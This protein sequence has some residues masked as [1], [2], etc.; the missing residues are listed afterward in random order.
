MAGLDAKTSGE[1]FRKDHAIILSGNRQLASIMAGRLTSNA[2]D[3]LAGQVV[4]RDPADSLYKK[5][6]A[7]SGS[8]TA[9]GI[10]LEDVAAD[11]VTGQL[12]RIVMGG[13]VFKDKCIDLNS[14]AIT[15]LGARSL[16][17]A[18]GTNILKF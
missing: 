17:S 8:L 12:A 1:I 6:S 4:A 5:W 14:T 9:A 10:L 2:S 11:S 13:E 7:V 15:G 16:V 18:L 3:W